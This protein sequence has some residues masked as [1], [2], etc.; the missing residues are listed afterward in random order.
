MTAVKIVLSIAYILLGAVSIAS[1]LVYYM[2]MFQLNSYMADEQRRFMK[3]KKG[4]L[5]GR[6]MGYVLSFMLLF[7]AA[8]DIVPVCMLCF[9]ALFFFMTAW[10]NRP[11]A[12]VAKRPL[13][14]TGRVKRMF[15]TAGILYMLILAVVITVS[16]VFFGNIIKVA[17]VS[18]F[19]ICALGFITPY[20]LFAANNQ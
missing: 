3:T 4:A 17:A 1:L 13:A 5:L 20:I 14:V 8:F 16:A 6:R 11:W 15:V 9:S 7:I 12:R 18:G 2:H 19:A 10:G